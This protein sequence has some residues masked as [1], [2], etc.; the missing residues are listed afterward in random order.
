MNRARL[1]VESKC[2]IHSASAPSSPRNGRVVTA[3]AAPSGRGGRSTPPRDRWSR[4]SRSAA[5]S[6]WL[7]SSSLTHTPSTW[8]HSETGWPPTRRTVSPRWQ[9]PAERLPPAGAARTVCPVYVVGNAPGPRPHGRVSVGVD[10]SPRRAATRHRPPGRPTAAPAGRGRGP[11][12]RRRLP[13]GHRSAV[14]GRHR[15]RRGRRGPLRRRRRPGHPRFPGRAGPGPA[16]GGWRPAPGHSPRRKWPR[17][18]W[19]T[20]G[21]PGRRTHASLGP[22]PGRGRP[23]TD[24]GAARWAGGHGGGRHRQRS[25]KGTTATPTGGW[26]TW[27]CR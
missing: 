24:Y 6:H 13:A 2:S 5:C 3:P 15:G 1:M 18:P 7:S 14:Q 21:P 17:S 27:A 8:G 22:R 10:P 25:V 9:W 23:G 16:G 19:R 26:G 4:A 12:P 20:S 11:P